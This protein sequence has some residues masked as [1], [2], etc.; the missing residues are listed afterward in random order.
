LRWEP[1]YYKESFNKNYAL[2]GL[3][4]GFVDALDANTI[5]LQF[6]QIFKLTEFFNS[7]GLIGHMRYCKERYNYFT[8]RL[9]Q[10]VANRV[11]QHHCLAPR[12]TS[13]YWKHNHN[14]AKTENLLDR[15]FEDL[16]AYEHSPA[17]YIRGDFVPFK[18]HMYL[19]HTLY[20]GADMSR[21]CR[22]STPEMLELAD[23]HF[24]YYNETNRLRA[25][26]APSIADWYKEHQ[27]EFDNF[28]NFR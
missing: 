12:D 18:A 26:I 1:G 6:G 27:I 17:A 5:A 3:A 15:A 7:H 23:K 22:S 16:A 20:F 2:V 8:E 19:T 4:S 25:S 13:E 28:I 21:R 10:N 9:Q 14:V 11:E 24:S